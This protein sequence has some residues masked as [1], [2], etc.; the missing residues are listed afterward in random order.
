MN[1]VA[2]RCARPARATLLTRA[3]NAERT[4]DVTLCARAHHVIAAHAAR[5]HARMDAATRLDQVAPALQT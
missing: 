4:H 1:A 5:T 3:R 2:Q